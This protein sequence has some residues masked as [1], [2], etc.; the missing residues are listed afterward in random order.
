MTSYQNEEIPTHGQ[1][2]M[3][4][5]GLPPNGK[6]TVSGFNKPLGGMADP[7]RPGSAQIKQTRPFVSQSIISFSHLFF[8]NRHGVQAR[9]EKVSIECAAS[10][11]DE[12][13]QINGKRGLRGQAFYQISYQS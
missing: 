7:N 13:D 1:R 8:L 4:K 9:A 6:N 3:M 11:G 12:L 2:M 5:G 10:K